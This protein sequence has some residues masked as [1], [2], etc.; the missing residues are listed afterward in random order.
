MRLSR[1]STYAIS[2][3]AHIAAQGGE[4]VQGR[5]IAATCRLPLEYLLKILQR[6]THAGILK[7]ERGRSGGFHLSRPADEI[8]LREIVEAME[9]PLQPYP[10]S[11][12][13]DAVQQELARISRQ[14]CDYTADLLSQTTLDQI[15][16]S[17][18]PVSSG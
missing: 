9:G 12:S 4:P 7:S 2:A 10:I 15:A 11:S 8:T 16:H 13:A 6:L 3:L 17:S 5:C 18:R 1:A 14:V